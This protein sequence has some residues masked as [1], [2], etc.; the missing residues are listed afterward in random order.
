M[1]TTDALKMALYRENRKLNPP[2]TSVL[3]YE[4]SYPA[5]ITSTPNDSEF[6]FPNS[7]INNMELEAP[8]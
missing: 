1:S 2:P 4:H 3:D 5:S 8:G 7:W 6:M